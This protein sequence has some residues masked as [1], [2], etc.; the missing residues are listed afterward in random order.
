MWAGGRV[1]GWVGVGGC[2]WMGDRAFGQ[3]TRVGSAPQQ[4]ASALLHR[5]C[6]RFH[7]TLVAD[8]ILST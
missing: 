3:L 2:E 8:C 5:R 1:S 7:D 4:H 6:I